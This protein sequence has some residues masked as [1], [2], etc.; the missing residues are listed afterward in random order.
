MGSILEFGSEEQKQRWL[1]PMA[2]LDRIGAFAL[3]ADP[4]RGARHHRTQRLHPFELPA[5]AEQ[6]HDGGTRPP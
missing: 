6:Q 2:R 1:P 3:T 5:W 4:H